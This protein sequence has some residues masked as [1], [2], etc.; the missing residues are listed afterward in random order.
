EVD[1]LHAK[2]LLIGGTNEGKPGLRED[3]FY[4]SYFRDLDGNKVCFYCNV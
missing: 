2:A 3:G 4:A 1:T